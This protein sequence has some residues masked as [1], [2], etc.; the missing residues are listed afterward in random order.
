MMY[1]VPLSTV[2]AIHDDQIKEFG[3][4][5]GVRDRNVLDSA[6]CQPQARFGGEYLHANIYEMAAAYGFHLC[7]NHPFFDGN[8]RTACMT[9]ITFLWMND[10]ALSFP[11]MEGYGV[12][13]AVP[14]GRL[15]KQ[16]LA[17]WL[18]NR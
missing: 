16:D 15:S 1:F 2:L 18:K 12:L 11:F 17:I 6:L 4:L 14:E 13:M 5:P 8:K 3:G 10:L 9:M 7:K